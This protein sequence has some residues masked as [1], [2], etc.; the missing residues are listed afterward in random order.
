MAVTLPGRDRERLIRTLAASAIR[1]P[2]SPA[3]L[4]FPDATE[5]GFARSF[6]VST[7]SQTQ[8]SRRPAL[9]PRNRKRLARAFA[10]STHSQTQFSH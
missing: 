8:F 5:N 10:V 9:S 1:R 4:R 3:D 6:A 7:H 2:L